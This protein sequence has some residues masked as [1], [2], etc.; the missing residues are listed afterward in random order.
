MLNYF[1]QF[2]KML[3]PFLPHG[4]ALLPLLLPGLS[5]GDRQLPGRVPGIRVRIVQEHPVLLP[6]GGVQ[7][8]ILNQHVDQ[9]RGRR[10]D[11]MLVAELHHPLAGLLEQVH[12][13]GQHQAD[14]VGIVEA[15]AGE[16][17]DA[18]LRD[19]AFDKL[20]VGLELGE[21]GH[22]HADHHVHCAL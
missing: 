9:A 14:R 11:E 15:L 6:V 21:A 2:R 5:Q 20:Q 10:A 12:G 3:K 13:D 18:L 16:A 8:V 7:R 22:V 1:Y 17:E 19:K 4:D